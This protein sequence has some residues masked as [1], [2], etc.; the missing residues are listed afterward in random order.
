MARIIPFGVIWL[1]TGWVFIL[2]ETAA[3]GTL[4]PDSPTIIGLNFKVFVFASIS[5]FIVGLLVGALEMI[6]MENL[7]RNRSF[8]QKILYKFGVYTLIV[9]AIIVITYPIAAGFESEIS[10][11]DVQVWEKFFRYLASVTFLSTLLQMASSLLL[12][13]I[14]AAISENL[15]HSVLTNFFTGKYHTPR[16]EN[17]I[18]MFLDMKSSTS[19][20]EHLGHIRYF[21]LLSEYYSDLSNAIINHLGEVYQY[22]GDEVVISWK[23]RAGL[24]NNN[25]IKCFFAMQKDLEKRKGFYMKK[26]GLTPSFKAGMHVGEV[27]T[28]EIGALKKEIFFTGDVLN[29]TS[30]IQGLCNQHNADFLASGDLIGQLHPDGRFEFKSLGLTRLKGRSEPIDLYAVKECVQG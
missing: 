24:K 27:T 19:V 13:L 25:C 16:E 5:I 12:C 28:G 11:M 4:D 15:G 20:A 9:L 29:A 26:F 30:R 17:R 18:F 7:F 21:E 23:Y 8:L 1:L 22:I 14:Y 3:M 10:I 6:F 2:V